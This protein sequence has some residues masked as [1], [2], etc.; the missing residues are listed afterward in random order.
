MMCQI[1]TSP[2]DTAIWKN[3]LRK[4]K[5]KVMY[6]VKVQG[7]IVGPA[8]RR[9]IPLSFFLSNLKSFFKGEDIQDI[10]YYIYFIHLCQA[11]AS[12]WQTQ[13]LNVLSLWLIILWYCFST[14]LKNHG[15]T[16]FANAAL[17]ALR[18]SP[19]FLQRLQKAME[20]NRPCTHTY[21]IAICN[22][23]L[24]PNIYEKMTKD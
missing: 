12:M 8:S 4:S 17:Q 19:G 20:N 22:P 10:S 5:A 24:A 18:T 15:N 13:E 11:W 16:C 23:Y 1:L 6:R 14:G 2:L 21:K 7:H 9:F 3:C